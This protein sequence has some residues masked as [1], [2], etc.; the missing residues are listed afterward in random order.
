MTRD[1]IVQVLKANLNK[2]VTLTFIDGFVTPATPLTVDAD[3]FIHDLATKEDHVF[4]V[5]FE[6]VA[7][8]TPESADVQP[9]AA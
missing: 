9:P 8:V 2:T 5:P 1:E 4:W 6:E 3:G 7:S